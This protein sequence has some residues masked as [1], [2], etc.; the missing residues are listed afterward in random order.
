MKILVLARLAGCMLLSWSALVYARRIRSPSRAASARRPYPVACSNVAQDFSRVPR[1]RARGA[2]LGRRSAQQRHGSLHHGAAV[3]AE[4]DADVR[5]T[6]PDDATLFGPWRGQTLTDVAIVCYPTS[7]ANTRPDY[8]LP[9]GKS[10]P[11]MQRGGERPDPSGFDEP[12]ARARVLARLRRAAR[13]RT[14]TSKPSQCSHRT[15]TSSSRRSMAT[16]L[17]AALVRRP[18][19]RSRRSRSSS[20][21]PRCRRCVRCRYPLRS[22]WCLRIRSGATVSISADRRLRRE[23]GRRDDDAARRRRAHDVDL[24]GDEAGHE[25]RRT[26]GGRRLRAVL[27]AAHPARVRP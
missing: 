20:A 27:R 21:I 24:P 1:G 18:E 22:T 6:P 7:A 26:Q 11:H 14:A 15:A 4:R 12:L 17:R 16:P 23:P 25:G 19:R 2:D 10:V 3:G 9:N 13:C 5:Y 8:P